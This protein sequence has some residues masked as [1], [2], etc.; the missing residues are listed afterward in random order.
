M[1]NLRQVHMRK[2]DVLYA[3]ACLPPLAL[4]G[5]RDPDLRE[6]PLDCGGRRRAAEVLACRR[7]TCAA[8]EA[9]PAFLL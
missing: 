5:P 7:S 1:H 2:D 9:G 8:Q 4:R 3:G 6:Q